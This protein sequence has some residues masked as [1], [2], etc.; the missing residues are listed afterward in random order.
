MNFA[1]VCWRCFCFIFYIAYCISE[2][3]AAGD[4]YVFKKEEYEILHRIYQIVLIAL[5]SIESCAFIVFLVQRTEIIKKFLRIILCRDDS[6]LCNNLVGCMFTM[7]I[8]F[9]SSFIAAFYFMFFLF[10]T[11]L[12]LIDIRQFF[13]KNTN[14]IVKNL[15]R[16]IFSLC[17]LLFLMSINIATLI[18]KDKLGLEK[19][20]VDHQIAVLCFTIALI[21]A[22]CVHYIYFELFV[23]N[24]LEGAQ[25]EIAELKGQV[26]K[27]LPGLKKYM[28]LSKSSFMFM[29]EFARFMRIS[30]M[31]SMGCISNNLCTSIDLEHIFYCH[32]VLNIPNTKFGCCYKCTGRKGYLVGFHQTSYEAA[33][34]ISLSPMRKTK[35]GM[36]G[37]GIYFAR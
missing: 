28:I 20:V 33:L 25:Q 14:Y 31:G 17:L 24:G 15:L 5:V 34:K 29:P 12:R 37:D 3:V 26:I 35:E 13:W 16:F 18:E 36:F 11:I 7:L 27:D 2:N 9:Y 8:L 19:K 23:P 1:I 6:I 21:I 30:Q 32:S 10:I 4:L 22:T